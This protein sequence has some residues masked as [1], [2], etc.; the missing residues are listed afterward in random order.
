VCFHLRQGF[1][2]IGSG[3]G[4][5]AFISQGATQHLEES[6]IVVHNQYSCHRQF[7]SET[8]VSAGEAIDFPC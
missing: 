5:K 2:S 4:P 1:V 7:S 6:L 8:E 3:H